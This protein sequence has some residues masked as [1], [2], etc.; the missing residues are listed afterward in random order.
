MGKSFIEQVG[1][2][3]LTSDTINDHIM[4]V[5]GLVQEYALGCSNLDWNRNKAIKLGTTTTEEKR[6]RPDVTIYYNRVL[7]MMGEEKDV[8]YRLEDAEKDLDEY[9]DFWNPLAFGRL[10]FVMAFAAAGTKLQF[11]YYV[12]NNINNKP[13]RK[14]I[15]TLIALGTQ[16]RLYNYMALQ[17]TINFIRILQTLNDYQ[18]LQTPKL[19]LFDVIQR[20]HGII[21]LL[22][23]KIIKKIDKD[24]IA[25]INFHKRFYNNIFP[26]LGQYKILNYKTT[27]NF[28][29]LELAPVGYE[30][31]PTNEYEL[32]TAIF[33]ILEI[34]KKLHEME[35]VHRDIRWENI[36][37]LTN[38]SWILIDFEEVA[39][40][41]ELRYSSNRL[42]E[43][44]QAW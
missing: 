34:V 28:I 23:Q 42:I 29:Y 17:Y 18:Y 35:V 8:K 43:L 1:G 37:R 13:V 16:N 22:P 30:A 6:V 20:T 11:Y 5:I 39:K 44:T 36:I 2:E 7:V 31:I 38:D 33:D 3:A 4:D 10:P 12:N 25:D 32:T 41:G 19:K 21:T 15:G 24:S 9:F 40:I 26:Y 14:K 27:R